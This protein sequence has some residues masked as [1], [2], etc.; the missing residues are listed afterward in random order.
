M[1][2]ISVDFIKPALTFHNF[3]EFI[4][5]MKWIFGNKI[6]FVAYPIFL[7]KEKKYTSHR[8]NRFFFYFAFLSFSW[9]RRDKSKLNDLQLGNEFWNFSFVCLREIAMLEFS[10]VV[11]GF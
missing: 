4:N 5:S 8:N 11:T 6:N 3:C 7:K 2:D 9:E 1:F 10:A